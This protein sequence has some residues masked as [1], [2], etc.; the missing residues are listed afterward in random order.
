MKSVCECA[1]QQSRGGYLESCVIGSLGD[2]GG[3]LCDVSDGWGGE[4]EG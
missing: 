1:V 3:S 2:N 4:L